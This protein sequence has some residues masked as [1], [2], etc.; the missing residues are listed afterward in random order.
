MNPNLFH[1]EG[2]VG[3]E[4]QFQ[5]QIQNGNQNPYPKIIST[6]NPY[7]NKTVEGETTSLNEIPG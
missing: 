2:E 3:L 4:F 7:E 6:E 5:F 1:F